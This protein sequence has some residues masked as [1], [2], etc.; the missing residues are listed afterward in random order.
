MYVQDAISVEAHS[1]CTTAPGRQR[2]L[3]GAGTTSNRFL[4]GAGLSL[5]WAW[6]KKPPKPNPNL[7]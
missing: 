7:D 6:C 4:F 3:K 1:F 5:V 2:P